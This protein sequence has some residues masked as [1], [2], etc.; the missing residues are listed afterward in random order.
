MAALERG[1]PY[2][3]PAASSLADGIAVK[4]VGRLTYEI[5]RRY[6]D[7][8]VTVEEDE[9]AN[10]VLLFLEIE[11]ILAEGAGAVPLAAL[12]ARKVPL[13]GQT[14]LSIVSGGN[15]DVNILNR[16][17]TRGL[18]VDGRIMECKIRLRDLPGSLNQVLVR[19]KELQANVLDISH[20]RYA[21]SAPLGYVDISITLETKGH[22]HVEQIEGVLGE[23]RI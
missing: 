4:Q 9:I 12:L 22:H 16:I 14:V 11:K 6:V 8:I 21:S 2:P 19:L 10:A 7:E 23:Y 1:A 13:E 3:L 17:I 20:H 15:I 18:R 5:A